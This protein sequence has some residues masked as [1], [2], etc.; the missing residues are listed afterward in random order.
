LVK[1]WQDRV[2]SLKKDGKDDRVSESLAYFESLNDPGVYGGVVYSKGGL[3]FYALR[4]EIGDQAFFQAL[5][6]YFHD[7]QYRIARPA[8]LLAEFEAASGRNLDAFFQEWLY[9]PAP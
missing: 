1:Y 6:N 5:Q 9:S 4:Q 8:D 7:Y 2:D 3:F